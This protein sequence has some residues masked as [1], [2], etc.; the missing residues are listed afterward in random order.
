MGNP[1]SKDPK[2]IMGAPDS[3]DLKEIEEYNRVIKYIMKLYDLSPGLIVWQPEDEATIKMIINLLEA[4]LKHIQK[5]DDDFRKTALVQLTIALIHCPNGQVAG[6]QNLFYAFKQEEAEAGVKGEREPQVGTEAETVMQQIKRVIA[7]EKQYIFQLT[8]APGGQSQNV[9]VLTHWQ[10]RLRKELGLGE[11]FKLSMGTME[12]DPFKGEA[13]NALQAFY[14][15]FTPAHVIRKIKD[16]VNAKTERK[17]LLFFEPIE[18]EFITLRMKTTI[19]SK[20]KVTLLLKKATEPFMEQ[21]FMK[22]V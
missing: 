3:K 4:V 10:T 14:Q 18:W 11:P 15:K 16:W 17:S 9:H 6:L 21:R 19:S 12:Q 22:K 5:L 8:F 7:A 13:G 20:W 2:E 1:N